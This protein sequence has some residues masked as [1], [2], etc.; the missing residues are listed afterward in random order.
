MTELTIV[1]LSAAQLDA[2]ARL[3][4]DAY[5]RQRRLTPA[6]PAAAALPSLAGF[7]ENG[8]GVAALRGGRLVGFIGAHG[9]FPA[10]GLKDVSG[11]FSP[12]HSNG[13]DDADEA[14]RAEIW[15][16]ML[17]AAMEK[18]AA[19]GAANHAI[20]LYA[21]DEAAQ[22]TLYRL[23]FGMRCA[24]AMRPLA[25]PVATGPSPAPAGYT[26]GPV[27]PAA[28]PGL[29]PLAAGLLEH[30]ARAPMHM[31]QHRPAAGI[32]QLAAEMA[33]DGCRYFAA[34]QGAA[35]VAYLKTG[36]EGETFAAALPGV[37]NICGAYCL[38]VHR[39]TGVY[40]ALLAHT[41]ATLRGEGYTHLGVDCESFNPTAWAYWN[42]HF[43]TY[44]HSLARRIDCAG[45][46]V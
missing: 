44:A 24:D 18:W 5:N 38:P 28:L 29:A 43:S 3:A 1:N 46:A 21:G 30:L 12:I 27:P 35:P 23:G 8:L 40:T 15:A 7:A 20:A 17:P 14:D 25:Q 4:L 10:Y 31:G 34:W 6:L 36:G 45:P 39:G 37:Q 22:R 2:A 26:Y 19:A 33:A 11:V 13:V 16:R 9:P 42:K 32:G 41:A